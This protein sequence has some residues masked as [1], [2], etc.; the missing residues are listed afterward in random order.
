MPP[1]CF[2]YPRSTFISLLHTDLKDFDE[3][4]K[5][6]SNVFVG[7]KMKSPMEVIMIASVAY[8]DYVEDLSYRKAMTTKK[9]LICFLQEIL[10]NDWHHEI[11]RCLLT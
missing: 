10:G 11:T 4:T 1:R 3:K 6:F 2:Y 9:H 5:F 7:E 8:F